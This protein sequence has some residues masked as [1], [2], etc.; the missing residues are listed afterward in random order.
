MPPTRRRRWGSFPTTADEGIWARA[1]SPAGLFEA[2]GLGLYAL[3]TD[4]RR[5]RPLEERELRVAATD[6]PSL[7][8]A[9][10]SQLLVLDATEGFLAR[11]VRVRLRG[12]PPTSLTA[13][14]R[15]ERADPARHRRR[16]EVKAVTYHAL[17]ADL[18]RGRARVIVDI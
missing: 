8:V 1:D 10:L 18:L 9:W 12:N 3:S 4:L 2:L 13:T 15:G 7:V 14:L 6:V 5:V 17:E 11:E 16:I